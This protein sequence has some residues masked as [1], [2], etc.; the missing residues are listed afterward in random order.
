MEE[1]LQNNGAQP[2][3][4]QANQSVA[5][6]SNTPEMADRTKEQ[7][8]KLT[9]SNQALNQEKER[10]QA[11]LNALRAQQ[12][13]VQE[14]QPTVRE[15]IQQAQDS[16]IDP[17]AYVEIDPN[18]GERFVNEKKLN[19]VISELQSRTVKAEQT[20]N[21]YVKTS[22]DRRIQQQKEEAFS[23]HPELEPGSDKFDQRFYQKVRATLRDSM[24]NAGEYGKVFSLKE[25]ADFV[26]AESA[27]TQDSGKSQD[28]Q[29]QGNPKAEAGANTPSQPQNAPRPTNSDEL[30][31][32]RLATRKGDVN[33]LAHRLLATDHVLKK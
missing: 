9:S 25:A 18:T 12:A 27:G 33:A 2:T 30:K 20:I 5:P 14:P 7:F 3:N 22:E 10:L 13:P 24:F 6:D 11:E 4:Q 17:T 31:A 1:Q 16:G 19:Q 15:N 8:E 29:E 28:K 32:L 23:A 21:N 26:K